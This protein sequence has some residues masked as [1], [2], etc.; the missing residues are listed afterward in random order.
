VCACADA[1]CVCA[2]APRA[3]SRESPKDHGRDANA[4]SRSRR[5]VAAHG[6]AVA[7]SWHSTARLGRGWA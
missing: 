3:C 4:T 7:G 6:K 1:A 2:Q 5:M